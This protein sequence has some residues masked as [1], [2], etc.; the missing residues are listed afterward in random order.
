MKRML[1]ALG[2]VCLLAG[3]IWIVGTASTPS[4]ADIPACGD[5]PCLMVCIGDPPGGP[6]GPGGQCQPGDIWQRGGS[7]GLTQ[8]IKSDGTTLTC[9]G[10]KHVHLAT[11]SQCHC[12]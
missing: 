9:T 12:P 7:T 6:C 3:I 2:S 11:S 10:G 1:V 8:C 4:S 5:H